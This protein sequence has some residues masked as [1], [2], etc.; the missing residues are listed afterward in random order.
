MAVRLSAL[1]VGRPL[2]PGR[3]LVLISVRGLVELKAIERLEGLGQLK[4]QLPHQ[5]SNP[6][7]LGL[8]HNALLLLFSRI[9]CN[10]PS[11]C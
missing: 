3:F 8:Y 6:R 4:F 7:P 9:L 5:E 11:G 10:W 1:R 2:P